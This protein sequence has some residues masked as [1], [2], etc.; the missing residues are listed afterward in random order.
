MAQLVTL[1]LLYLALALLGGA[2]MCTNDRPVGQAIGALQMVVG[3]VG[4]T[5]MLLKILQG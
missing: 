2:Y 4:V 5:A 3:L 1:A